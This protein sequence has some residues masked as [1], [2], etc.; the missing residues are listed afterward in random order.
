M[1]VA[2]LVSVTS[3]A[4]ADVPTTPDRQSATLAFEVCLSS[5]AKKGTYTASDGG[6]SAL[7]LM[8]QCRPQ[9]DEWRSQCMATGQTPNQCNVLAAFITNATLKRIEPSSKP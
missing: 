9:W 4:N 8:K 1:A 2:G 5:E 7:R 3:I 6:I